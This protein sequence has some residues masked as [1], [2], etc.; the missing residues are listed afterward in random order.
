MISLFIYIFLIWCRI[1]RNPPTYL[2]LKSTYEYIDRAL[3]HL[4]FACGFSTYCIN[5]IMQTLHHQGN[6]MWR[7]SSSP[8]ADN[9]D[10]IGQSSLCGEKNVNILQFFII[11]QLLYY[12]LQK[13]AFSH[14]SYL[15]CFISTNSC[16]SFLF[17]CSFLINNC[18]ANKTAV[19]L[20]KPG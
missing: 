7:M 14:E 13:S 3:I 11:F 1:S 6:K 16:C 18:V 5:I 4:E 17:Q 19:G 9:P 2:S 20:C 15:I 8:F 10:L 12:L